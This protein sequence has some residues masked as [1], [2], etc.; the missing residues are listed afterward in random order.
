MATIYN[1]MDYAGFVI[2]AKA[3]LLN[4]STAHLLQKSFTILVPVCARQQ[5]KRDV[6]LDQPDR[7]LESGTVRAS[8]SIGSRP[9]AVGK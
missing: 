7:L 4:S 3:S 5:I 8:W 2:L 9:N 6:G 1:S